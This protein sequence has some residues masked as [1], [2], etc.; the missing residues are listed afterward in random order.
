MTPDELEDVRN[1]RI[2]PRGNGIGLNN[3]RERLKIA[4]EESLF[5][6]DS[7]PGKGTVVQIRIP[8]KRGEEEHVQTADR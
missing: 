1:F 6:I 8:K 3:I 5:E 7:A 2:K 4:Y